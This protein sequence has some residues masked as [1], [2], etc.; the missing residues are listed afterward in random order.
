[1][2]YKQETLWSL[3]S[4]NTIVLFTKFECPLPC[5]LKLVKCRPLLMPIPRNIFFSLRL[6]LPNYLF[7]RRITDLLLFLISIRDLCHQFQLHHFFIIIITIITIS[8]LKCTWLTVKPY[9][10]QSSLHPYASSS[11]VPS[12]F[13]SLFQNTTPCFWY[14]T[15]YQNKKPKESTRKRANFTTSQSNKMRCFSPFMEIG[16]LNLLY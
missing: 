11:T 6:I 1:M 5:S 13:S 10:T 3:G 15:T 8:G 2:Y 14:G 9:V 12:S 7:A 16:K 4:S